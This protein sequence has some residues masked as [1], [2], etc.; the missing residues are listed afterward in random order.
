MARPASMSRECFGFLTD[1]EQCHKQGMARKAVVAASSPRGGPSDLVV[2]RRNPEPPDDF[3]PHGTGLRPR[4]DAGTA[5]SLSG[6]QS[7]HDDTVLVL[8]AAAALDRD[9]L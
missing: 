4:T 1:R 7:D 2:L 8:G 9:R 5:K 3:S 6:P